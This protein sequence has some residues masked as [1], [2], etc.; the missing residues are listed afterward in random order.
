MTGTIFATFLAFFVTFYYELA[1]KALF[2]DDIRHYET[3][4]LQK[5]VCVSTLLLDVSVTLKFNKQHNLSVQKQTKKLG[6]F[7][8]FAQM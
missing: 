8:L 6:I 5:K 7:L 4:F 2:C 3:D 1:A